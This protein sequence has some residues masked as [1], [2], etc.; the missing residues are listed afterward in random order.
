[1]IMDNRQPIS[2]GQPYTAAFTQPI[3]NPQ[4]ADASQP[5]GE[6]QMAQPMQMPDVQPGANAG[7]GS[8]PVTGAPMMMQ[9]PIASEP[10]I[11]YRKEASSLV[12]TIV[13]IALS[14]VSVTFIGLFVW[15]FMLYSGAKSDVDGQVADAVV[16]AVDENTTKLEG[17]FAERE[18]YPF[19]TFAGPT[20]YGALTFEYP[21]TWSVYVARD[22]RNGGDFEAYFNPVEV[23]EVSNETID[24]LRL[25]SLIHI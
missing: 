12:K 3:N 15:M 21:Q 25:L 6:A 10:P 9:A 14:L 13:I 1:M 16:T 22:A 18:K 4:G 24:S 20:D 23:Y 19:Q 11:A 7:I 2:S 5:M 8:N 17:E